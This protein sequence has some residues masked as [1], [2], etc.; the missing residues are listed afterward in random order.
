[1][2]NLENGIARIDPKVY[3]GILSKL[4]RTYKYF[5]NNELPLKVIIPAVD[6]I[7]GVPVEVE[8]EIYAM[9]ST[10]GTLIVHEVRLTNDAKEVID[11]TRS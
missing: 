4:V 7:D 1:M 9:P 3:K 6:E 11:A 10:A 8:E 2:E 5:N